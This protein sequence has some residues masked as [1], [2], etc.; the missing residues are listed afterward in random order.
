TSLDTE[1]SS[2]VARRASTG[3]TFKGAFSGTTVS[4]ELSGSVGPPATV[5]PLP[6]WLLAGSLLAG[7]LLAESL[8]PPG[9]LPRMLPLGLVRAADAIRLRNSLSPLSV[10]AC[11]LDECGPRLG[12]VPSSTLESSSSCAKGSRA[13]ATSPGD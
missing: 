7:S 2:G 4:L 12:N 6:E 10:E 5:W 11:R 9:T 13:S 1:L 3:V 8:P